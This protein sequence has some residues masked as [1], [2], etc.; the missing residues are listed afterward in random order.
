MES[1]S[2]VFGLG[3]CSVDYIGKVDR[4]PCPDVKCECSDTVIQG[5]G[6]VATA[7]VALSRWGISCC[8]T[9]VIGNDLFG[10]IIKQSLEAF[11][12]GK[13]LNPSLHSLLPNLPEKGGEPSSGEGPLE[14]PLDRRR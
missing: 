10:G 5:G 12:S 9:G 13:G 4:F 7:L 1:T 14:I 6:P 11:L 2:E 3:Q 8:F